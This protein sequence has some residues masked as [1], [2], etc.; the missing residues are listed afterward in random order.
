M[1]WL[2]AQERLAAPTFAPLRPALERLPRDRWPTHEDLCEAARG[3]ETAGGKALAFVPPRGALDSARRAYE[4]RIDATGEVET[5]PRNWHDL[6]NALAWIAFPR[7]KACLN[8]QHAAILQDG[9][10]EEARRRGPERDALTLFDEGGVIVASSS[11]ALLRLIVEHEWKELFWN[12]RA[13]LEARVRFLAFGHGL[14]EKMLDPFVG[15]A[16][17]TIFVPVDELFFMLPPEAQVERADAL[18]ASYFADR[19]RFP[20]PRSMAPLPVLG[21]PGWHPAAD[22][23]SFYDDARYFRPGGEAA[24]A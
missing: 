16:A 9:G 20:S 17:K 22:R 21:V 14:Y 12:R 3:L 19:A 6:F 23:A 18:A 4:V 13:D 1:D 11:P 5:R 24:E 8:R 15:I 7:T 2:E 10:G